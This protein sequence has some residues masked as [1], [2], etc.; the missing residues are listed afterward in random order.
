MSESFNHRKQA[1]EH[2]QPGTGGHGRD[3]RRGEIMELDAALNAYI[4]RRGLRTP[5]ED[6]QR[7][8]IQQANTARTAAWRAKK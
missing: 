4:E 5:N 7:L 6:A 8:R 3:F 2:T 1:H